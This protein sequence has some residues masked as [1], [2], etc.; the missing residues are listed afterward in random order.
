M[1]EYKEFGSKNNYIL[2]KQRFIYV[3]KIR[4]EEDSFNYYR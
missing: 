1:I 3:Y 4:M 2:I